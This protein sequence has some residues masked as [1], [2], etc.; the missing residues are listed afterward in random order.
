MVIYVKK[1]S[2]TTL[3][4]YYTNKSLRIINNV[5]DEIVNIIMIII[6]IEFFWEVLLSDPHNTI[7]NCFDCIYLFPPSCIFLDHPN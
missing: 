5:E 2:G 1:T 3:L 6:I 4:I 7:L